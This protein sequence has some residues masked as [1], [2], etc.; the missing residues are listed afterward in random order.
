MISLLTIIYLYAAGT[1]ILHEALQL[2]PEERANYY[3]PSLA[4]WPAWAA[5]WF[6]L[7]VHAFIKEKLTK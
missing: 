5:V 7:Y 3:W 2:P 6:G 1:Y 4:A